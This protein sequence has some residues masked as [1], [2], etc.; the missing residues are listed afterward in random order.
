MGIRSIGKAMKGCG[1]I[2]SAG[3]VLA[4][5]EPVT[6]ARNLCVGLKA[7]PVELRDC[8]QWRAIA[9]RSAASIRS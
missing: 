1:L 6:V 3:T 9:A 5:F 7:E 8:E 4:L 2:V